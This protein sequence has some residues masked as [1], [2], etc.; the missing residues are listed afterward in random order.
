LNSAVAEEMHRLVGFPVDPETVYQL[1]IILYFESLENPN[2]FEFWKVDKFYTKDITP[3][4]RKTPL[5]KKGDLKHRAG[6]R[7][8]KTRYKVIDYDNRIKFLQDS[9]SKAIGIPNDCQIFSGY[10]A[11]REDPEYPRA[12]VTVHVKERDDYFRRSDGQDS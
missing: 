10:Q 4:R 11:K 5:H 9:L 6:E 2:W 8:A 1:D 12:E 3:K 7:K